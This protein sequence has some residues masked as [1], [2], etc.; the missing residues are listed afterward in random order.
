[1][2]DRTLFVQMV[3]NTHYRIPAHDENSKEN[4]CDVLYNK[5]WAFDVHD[6][7]INTSYIVHVEFEGDGWT[8]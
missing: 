4:V 3:N 7:V 6:N 5:V 1:M 8:D 2:S